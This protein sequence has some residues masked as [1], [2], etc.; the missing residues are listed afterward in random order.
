M[1]TSALLKEGPGNLYAFS[2]ETHL[3]H[4]RAMRGSVPIE[5]GNVQSRPQAAA[6]QDK[7]I[8]VLPS[9]A[10]YFPVKSNLQKFNCKFY[11][12]KS[13]KS[14]LAPVHKKIL[15]TTDFQKRWHLARS[16]EMVIIL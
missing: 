14:V 8:W 4:T 12:Q 10:K 1:E 9:T 11:S 13:Q 7:T 2:P 15:Q 3:V 5:N 16:T 6:R